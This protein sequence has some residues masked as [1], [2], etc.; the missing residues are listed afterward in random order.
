MLRRCVLGT[1]LAAPAIAW[2]QSPSA[3]FEGRW[4]G[5]GNHGPVD[6]TVAPGG[7]VTLL[8]SGKPVD[9]DAPTY[10]KRRMTVKTRRVSKGG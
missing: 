10:E 2:A 8:S 5:T 7:A 4:V 6:L 1:F 9:L 3:P